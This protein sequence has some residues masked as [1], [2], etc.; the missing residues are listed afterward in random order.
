MEFQKSHPQPYHRFVKQLHLAHE[1]MTL[2]ALVEEH[3][4]EQK[5]KAAAR[6]AE[7]SNS[8]SPLVPTQTLLDALDNGDL[9]QQQL[10]ELAH[11]QLLDIKGIKK[12]DAKA[13]RKI[14][15]NPNNNEE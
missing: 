1:F 12:R 14:Q 8:I 3:Y 6:R 4:D 10:V 11:Q 9:T 2:S 7:S 15:D 13:A 5:K